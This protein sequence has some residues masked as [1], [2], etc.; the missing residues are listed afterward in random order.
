MDTR[1]PHWRILILPAA[2]ALACVVLTLLVFRAF[3]GGLPLEPHGYRF[4]L[5][6]PDASNLTR[7]SDVQI[8]GVD[9]GK[10]IEVRRSGNGALA[11]LEL[12]PRYV[13]LGSGARATLRSKTLLGEAYVEIAPGPETAAPIPEGGALAAAQV[14]PAVQ[15]DEFLDTFAPAT[16]RRMRRLLAG[17]SSVVGDRG[18]ALNDSLGHAAPVTANL[19]VV[20]DALEAQKGDLSQLFDKSG[21]VLES[22]GRRQ[23]ALQAAVVAGN[24]ILSATGR[25]D[26]ELGATVHEL[27]PFLTQL[28]NTSRTLTAASGDL[29]RAVTSL[30][31]VAP[32][33]RPALGEIVSA[34]PEVR[35]LFRDLPATIAA[36][37]RGLPAVRGISRAARSGFRAFYPASR[38][39]IPILQLLAVNRTI[40]VSVFAN[41]AQ[42]TNGTFVGPGGLVH[43]Y[44]PAIPTVWNETISGWK[45]KLPTNRQNPYP[46]PPDSLLDTGRLGY[47]KSYDCRH[48]GNPLIIPATGGQGAPPCVLQ[49]PWEFNGKSAFYPRLTLAPR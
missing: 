27:G 43:H 24:D 20:L 46:K 40:P 37:N 35:G 11:T 48:V 29:N 49:G 26:R 2:F 3:G 8:S 23:G 7:G 4:T 18:P 34:A 16:R 13:P 21:D 17:M 33:V 28:R 38:E 39:L 32:L 1:T 45:H 9:V 25:R 31:P 30:L 42:I 14:R 5:P 22:L 19:A 12:L 10:V 36:G 47:L 15:L 6:M 44:A 41:V